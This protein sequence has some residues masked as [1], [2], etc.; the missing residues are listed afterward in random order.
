M[1]DCASVNNVA[2]VSIVI[3]YPSAIDIGCFSHTLSH[4]GKKFNVPVLAKFMKH[5]ERMIQQSHK[6][7]LVWREITGRGALDIQS[8][9][10][11]EHV[12]MP[13]TASGVVWGYVN[14]F[15]GLF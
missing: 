9:E 10:M 4:V 13:A 5:W 7:C 8:N 3:L 1:R 2:V 15:E 14:V 6:A 12:G 11:V